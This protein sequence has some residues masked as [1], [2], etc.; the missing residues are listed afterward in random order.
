LD[1][2]IGLDLDIA[3]IDIVDFEIDLNIVGIAVIDF[4]IVEVDFGI[5]FGRNCFDIV[6]FGIGID[7][8]RYHLK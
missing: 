3:E 2:Y 6:D 1:F 8:T 7:L 5:Y 4:G